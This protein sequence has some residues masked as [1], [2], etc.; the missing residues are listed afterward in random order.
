[1]VAVLIQ[2]AMIEV[3]GR[4]AGRPPVHPTAVA[5]ETVWEGTRGLAAD[6][7]AY[8]GWLRSEAQKRIGKYYLDATLTDGTKA[9]PIA[10]IWAR[11]VRSPDPSW[12]GEVPL[13]RS[14]VLA[15]K[16]GK[17]VV[18]AA[19]VVDHVNQSIRYEIRSGGDPA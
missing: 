8:G 5:A 2:R 3:P 7:Q 1:P 13:V 10:W 14:W 4:F 15:K 9:M 6:V 18:W 16:P 11:T 19:P 12:P 17:P